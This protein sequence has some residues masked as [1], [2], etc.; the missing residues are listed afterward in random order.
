MRFLNVRVITTESFLHVQVHGFIQKQ[1][2]DSWQVGILL[3]EL[4]SEMSVE[5]PHMVQELMPLDGLPL[6]HLLC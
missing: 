6:N 2:I 5:V 1:F 4:D 3:A